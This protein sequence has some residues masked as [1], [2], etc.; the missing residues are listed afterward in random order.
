M[1]EICR[2][3]GVQRVNVAQFCPKIVFLIHRE[4]LA[5]STLL[6]IYVC[7]ILLPMALRMVCPRTI[8]LVTCQAQS[9]LLQVNSMLLFFPRT[10]YF[11]LL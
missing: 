2:S 8:Q 6:P 11:Y 5:N 7:D 10:S 4:L 1:L 9:C 3:G